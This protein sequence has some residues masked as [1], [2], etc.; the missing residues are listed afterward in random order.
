MV[1]GFQTRLH[2]VA[3]R[4]SGLLGGTVCLILCMFLGLPPQASYADSTLNQSNR[5]LHEWA[6]FSITPTP[7]TEQPLAAFT[8]NSFDDDVD[9]NIGDG[10]C[11]TLQGVC[12]LRAAIQEANS[13]YDAAV[14]HLPSGTYRLSIPGRAEDKSVTGDLDITSPLTL[15]G[16]GSEA[17][18]IDGGG[19]DRV[20]D[21]GENAHPGTAVTIAHLTIRGGNDNGDN[22]P[23]GM[24]IRSYKVTLEDDIV[25]DNFGEGIGIDKGA[26]I[27]K[28]SVIKNNT[29]V[30]VGGIRATSSSLLIAESTISENKGA[31]GGIASDTWINV[32]N[33]TISGNK[34]SA[35]P[36]GLRLSGSATITNSTI[37]SN[38]GS[39]GAAIWINNGNLIIINS[40]IVANQASGN[41]SDWRSGAAGGIFFKGDKGSVILTHTILAENIS[42]TESSNCFGTLLSMGYNLIDKLDGCHFIPAETDLINTQPLLRPLQNNG[43]AAFTHAPLPNSPAI[44]GGSP[45]GCT[46]RDQ[47]PLLRDQRNHSRPFDGN[48]D[49]I[50][51]CDIGAVEYD[52]TSPAVILPTSTPFPPA[53]ELSP[54]PQNIPASSE[55]LPTS[56]VSAHCKELVVNG[57]FESQVGWVFPQTAA[58]AEYAQGVAHSGKQSVRTGI[59]SPLN[60]VLSYSSIWQPVAIPADAEQATLSFW[61]YPVNTGPIEDYHGGDLQLALLLDYPYW[62]V[63]SSPVRQTLLALRSN[64]R[65]WT[66]YEYDLTP[67][68]GRTLW[69]YFGTYNNGWAGSWGNP[70]AMYVDDVS[71]LACS[72]K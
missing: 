22:A 50:A 59:L 35:G 40:T 28:N 67:Y 63:G 70:M 58:P 31:W 2:Q 9:G 52:G 47:T 18:I 20:L 69:L 41:G 12:T 56:I 33:S 16:S 65:T 53:V 36:G 23:A 21:V 3:P 64:S 34:G 49:G 60:N 51:V 8:V 11:A 62:S 30:G 45:R 13:S 5:L 15:L 72:P 39:E 6:S 17:T 66:R 27:L 25:S 71:L 46:Y 43:G 57:G 37:S 32:V 29:S 24:R 7:Q 1:Q 19:L 55:P 68:A 44:D 54:Q 61:I 48:G 4:F 10:I 38:V 26:L 14:I 42:S